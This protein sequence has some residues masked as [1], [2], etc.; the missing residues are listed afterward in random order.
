MKILLVSRGS[1]GDVY[2]YLALASELTALNH[3]ITISLPAVFEKE[4]KSFG[5]NY[6]LQGGDDIIGMV[7]HSTNTKDLLAWTQRVIHAQ[8]DELIPLVKRYDI[9]VASNTEFAAP[10]IAEYCKK[11]LIR[12]AYAPLLPGRKLPP[13]VMPI[14]RNP[15]FTPSLQWKVLN[16]GLNLMVKKT[17]NAH[18]K[19]LGMPPIGDQGEHAPAHARNYLMYSRFLGETDPDWA[20]DW[21][22]G[23]YCF[24]DL[25]QY[26]EVSYRKLLDFI[27]KDKKPAVFFTFGSCTSKNGDTF[28]EWLCDI[29]AEL[30]YKLIIGA[31]WWKH[32]AQLQEKTHVFLLTTAV[33]HNLVFPLCGAI[34]HHGGSGTTHSAGR[35]G[36]PQLIVPILLDQF[37]WGNRVYRLGV[38]PDSVN[39]AKISRPALA[40][41]VKDLVTNPEYQKNAAALGEQ[42]R[43]EQGLKT[44]CEYIATAGS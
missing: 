26:D 7:E 28:C 14:Q 33:P 41:K 19:Q 42:I 12:T 31:N 20:Y 30:D 18:R 11:T 10:T 40:V 6:A 34:I 29:C 16:I 17:L 1:Q 24:N 39:L 43:N 2:P 3:E 44:L 23:G 37:Y 25:M 13:P 9:M 4:A 35:A 8:F 5:L 32:G 21:S 38:G 36:K 27:Q 22:I 15:L